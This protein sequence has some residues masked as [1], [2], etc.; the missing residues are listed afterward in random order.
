MPEICPYYVVQSTPMKQMAMVG[1]ADSI[2][3]VKMILKM[4]RKYSRTRV[5]TQHKWNCISELTLVRRCFR[6]SFDSFESH[7]AC[8]A[9]C[10]EENV[11]RLV[12]IFHLR[13]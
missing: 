9:P 5:R 2:R 4:N 6:A 3:K 10:D 13:S 1:P 12:L 7:E 8:F 11:C